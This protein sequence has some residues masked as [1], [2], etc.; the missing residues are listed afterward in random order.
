[1]A[2]G[3][4]TFS[5]VFLFLFSF[6]CLLAWLAGSSSHISKMMT[7]GNGNQKWQK[8][9]KK[10]VQETPEE[11]LTHEK[12]PLESRNKMLSSLHKLDSCRMREMVYEVILLT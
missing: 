10:L 8:R 12:L 5:G 7:N 11:C 9:M 4:G 6:V 1:M 3:F 2:Y